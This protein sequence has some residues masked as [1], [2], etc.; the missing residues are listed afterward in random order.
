M[1]EDSTEQLLIRKNDVWIKVNTPNAFL[2]DQRDL[3]EGVLT[4]TKRERE[5]K[6][7][8]CTSISKQ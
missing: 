4:P 1:S 3:R 8:F 2:L 5:K 6:Y 7:P